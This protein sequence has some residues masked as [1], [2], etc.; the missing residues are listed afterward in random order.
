M[1]ERRKGEGKE[2]AEEWKKGNKAFIVRTAHFFPRPR[3]A[4]NSCPSDNELRRNSDANLEPSSSMGL[5]CHSSGSRQAGQWRKL[6]SGTGNLPFPVPSL[7]FSRSL[8]RC[9]YRLILV[10]LVYIRGQG[11]GKE[12]TP[13]LRSRNNHCCDPFYEQALQGP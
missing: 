13:E 12:V 10:V 3:P 9:C 1:K 4:P 6:G 5:Y 7:P 8:P 11:K 2:I